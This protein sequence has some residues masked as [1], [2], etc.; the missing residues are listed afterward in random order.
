MKYYKYLELP[1]W[2]N[3]TKKVLTYYFDHREEYIRTQ[4]IPDFKV[5]DTTD[6]LEKIPEINEMLSHLSTSAEEIWFFEMKQYTTP[7]GMI[8]MDNSPHESRLL[9]PLLNCDNTE[10][11]YYKSSEP[12]INMGNPGDPNCVVPKIPV[13]GTCTQVD[14]MYV[15]RGPVLMRPNELH[16]VAVPE[17]QIF[18]R[19]TMLLMIKD[20]LTHMLN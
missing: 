20:D 4:T 8:H 9:L 12:L 11:R 3:V 6:I 2:K 5:A 7:E 16:S 13:P 15:G 14:G 17:D 10:T 1:N 18:P 19:I